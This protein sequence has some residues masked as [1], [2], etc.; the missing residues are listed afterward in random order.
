[1]RHPVQEVPHKRGQLRDRLEWQLLHS[2]STKYSDGDG[3]VST[4]TGGFSLRAA[5]SIF[6]VGPGRADES[7]GT[8]R[9]AGADARHVAVPVVPLG[10]DFDGG[11]G[12]GAGAVDRTSGMVIFGATLMLLV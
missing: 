9:S 7:C 1:M 3:F 8:L 4:S 5:P 6:F 2:S 10:K 12:A 11:C